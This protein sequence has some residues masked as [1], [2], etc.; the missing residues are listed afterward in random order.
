MARSLLQS[1][2]QLPPAERILLV[3]QV[4]DSLVEADA[5][6][7]LSQTQLDELKQRELRLEK[8][9]S[10]GEDWTAVKQRLLKRRSKR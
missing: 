5:D 9:G 4:W 6:V 2:L 3:E 7:P 10:S 8:N 1:A